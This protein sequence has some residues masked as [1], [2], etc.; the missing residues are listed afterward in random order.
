MSDAAPTD[1]TRAARGVRTAH[2]RWFVLV[3]IL[4][5]I[6]LSIA[7]AVLVTPTSD[8]GFAA[9]LC[10]L[11]GGWAVAFAAVNALSGLAE[12]WQWAWHIALAAGALALAAWITPVIQ[13]LAALPEP[14]RRS[15]AVVALGIPSA[16]GWVL[17]TLLGRISGLFDRAAAA[18]AAAMA[19]PRWGGSDARP[20][21]TISASRF[22]VRTLTTL[23]AATVVA[24]GLLSTALMIV[25]ERWVLRLPPLMIAV[26]LGALIGMPLYA[27]VWGVVNRRRRRVTVRWRTGAIDVD[28]GERW[29]VPLPMIRRLVWCSRGDMARLE[30]H[31]ATR[32][33]TYLVGMVRQHDRSA[34]E[35]PPLQRRM[36]RALA[37]SGL[38]PTERRGVLRYDRAESPGSGADDGVS[39]TGA[40]RARD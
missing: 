2:R 10:V 36:Q 16:A 22:S 40:P 30:I 19:E 17:I 38:V 33:E 6:A 5:G 34:A 18:R 25:A 37:E 26:V 27:A 4:V 29:T 7:G 8:G 9:Y 15:L 13:A 21:L 12:R 39:A 31:T 28:A 1:A 23:I 11:I 24:A 35:L 32:S 3:P 20:E 14:W